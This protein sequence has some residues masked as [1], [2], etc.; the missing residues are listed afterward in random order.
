MGFLT[1]LEKKKQISY[2]DRFIG[3][4]GQENAIVLVYLKFKKYLMKFCKV[5]RFL[6]PLILQDSHANLTSSIKS[7]VI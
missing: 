2:S 1:S 4:S 3:L 5:L 7:S 6:L